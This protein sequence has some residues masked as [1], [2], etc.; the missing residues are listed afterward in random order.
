MLYCY[1]AKLWRL[2]GINTVLVASHSHHY[3]K[4]SASVSALEDMLQQIVLT[5]FKYVPRGKAR[6]YV[7]WFSPDEITTY[8]DKPNAVYDVITTINNEGK[9]FVEFQLF[10]FK[11]DDS[12]LLSIDS[13][14]SEDFDDDIYF[15]EAEPNTPAEDT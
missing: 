11:D 7:G 8:S 3:D 12:D 13:E 10:S 4:L 2:E 5:Q 9:Y 15:T 1:E 14:T 6:K